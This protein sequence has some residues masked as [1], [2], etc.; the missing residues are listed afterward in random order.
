M[1][2]RLARLMYEAVEKKYIEPISWSAR[3]GEGREEWYR[4]ADAL[5]ASEEWQAREAVVEAAR[6]CIDEIKDNARAER[7]NAE[8]CARG[9]TLG[10]SSPPRWHARVNLEAALARLAATK[11]KERTTA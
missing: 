1:R 8:N 3:V 4:V 10:P 7:F 9:G 6:R 2:D 5:L 11:A